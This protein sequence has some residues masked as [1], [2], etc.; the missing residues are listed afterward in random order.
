MIEDD[1]NNDNG[2][3]I[4]SF[5]QIPEAGK[6]VDEIEFNIDEEKEEVARKARIM[7]KRREIEWLKKRELEIEEEQLQRDIDELKN[8]TKG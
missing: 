7:Q 3:G 6:Y 1:G 5:S 4:G 2:Q 8:E